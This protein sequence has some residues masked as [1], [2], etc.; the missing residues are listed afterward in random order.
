M[1]AVTVDAMSKSHGV[2]QALDRISFAVHGGKIFG[3]VGPNGAGKTTT[4]RILATLFGTSG[5][6]VEVFGHDVEQ[7]PN[8]VRETIRYLPAEAGTYDNDIN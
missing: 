5:G 6:S 3:L 1:T 2:V 4:P 7:D 8:E